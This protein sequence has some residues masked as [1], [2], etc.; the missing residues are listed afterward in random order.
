MAS[1][2]QDPDGLA[3]DQATGDIYVSEEYR[4]AIIRI[5]TNGERIVLC[6]ADTPIFQAVRGSVVRVTGMRG[7]EGVA[8]DGKGLIYVVEDVVGGRLIKFLLADMSQGEVVPLP[9]DGRAYAWESIDANNKG[10]LLLAGSSMES[11]AA[12]HMTNSLFDGVILY[13]DVSGA[14][15]IPMQNGLA[16]YSA[17][18]FSPDGRSAYFA[19][20]LMGEVGCLDLES[21]T[22]R[23]YVADKTIRSPEGVCVLPD[24][25]ALVASEGGG[26]YRFDPVTRSVRLVYGCHSNI[27]SI[28]W[29]N[30]RHRLL[31]T[32]D[33]GGL[34]IALYADLHF[35]SPRE[36]IPNVAFGPIP[37]G[38][39]IPEK[40]PD[41]LQGVLKLGGFDPMNATNNTSFAEF[42]RRLSMVAVDSLA[43]MQDHEGPFG[44]PVKRVQFVVFMPN[45]FGIEMG[46]FTGPVSGFAA[47]QES[48][49]VVQTRMRDRELVHVRLWDGLV[50]V[51]GKKRVALPYPLGARLSAEGV[52]S[53]HFMGFGETPDYHVV[54][55]AR[56]PNESYMMVT[57]LDGRSQNYRLML[58]PGKDVSH[59]VL[60]LKPETPEEWTRASLAVP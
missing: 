28:A 15:W 1:H 59:W 54:L 29:D 40:C 30:E 14:W 47:I 19:D 44:D 56:H 60:A 58:P 12:G 31:V 18:C 3:I 48:G 39:T 35:Q 57:Y 10:E 55:N 37:F 6:D 8:L 4:A 20:E 42:A 45:L 24:G 32:S 41:Y 27:E 33:G 5:S 17:V 11:F 23:T 9:L 26:I 53:L 51:F 52:A 49:Y 16:S 25:S 13:R 36:F 7:I 50:S 43:V 38:V 22:L 21:R 46:E 34:L 2:I